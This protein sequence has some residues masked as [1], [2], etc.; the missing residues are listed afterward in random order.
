MSGIFNSAIFNNAI[1][2]VGV[3]VLSEETPPGVGRKRKQTVIR[4]SDA[5][6]ETT[7]EF[8][9]AQLK[10]R[11]G[12]PDPVKEIREK[13]KKR[14]IVAQNKREAK[15]RSEHE[16]EAQKEEVLKMN[17]AILQLIA[18]SHDA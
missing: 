1:F 14:L 4:L 18:I 5:D 6:R 9:K 8:L 10:L 11:Q 2:N 17:N 15:M 16:K 12:F 3:G 13:E 7:S